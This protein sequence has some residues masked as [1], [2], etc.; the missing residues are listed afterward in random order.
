MAWGLTAAKTGD[1]G[2]GTDFAVDLVGLLVVSAAGDGDAD[3]LLRW[4][5]VRDLVLVLKA[6]ATIGKGIELVV[7][8]GRLGDGGVGHGS[9]VSLR[10]RK[11]RVPRLAGRQCR[12]DRR[13]FNVQVDDRLN[14][15]GCG[16]AD[17]PFEISVDSDWKQQAREEK[18]KLAEEAAKR[19]RP[20]SPH[21]PPHRPRRGSPLRVLVAP[22]T[23]T[24]WSARFQNPC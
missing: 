6:I 13:L 22:P 11:V 1:G 16:M 18:R 5:R 3:L 7:R 23:S 19:P 4:A 21:P 2:V 12:C 24:G 10:V 8:V 9:V 17:S 14:G 20:P 15:V